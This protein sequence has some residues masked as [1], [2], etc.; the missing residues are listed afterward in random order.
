MILQWNGC[1]WECPVS[2]YCITFYFFTYLFHQHAVF[3]GCYYSFRAEVFFWSESN[4]IEVFV[5][6]EIAVAFYLKLINKLRSQAS[7]MIHQ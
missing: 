2:F 1:F 5:E 6:E 4:N 3:A 7:V